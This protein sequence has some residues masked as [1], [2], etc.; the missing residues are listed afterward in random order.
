MKFF[1]VRNPCWLYME[2]LAMSLAFSVEATTLSQSAVCITGWLWLYF[3][4]QI[5]LSPSLSAESA[6]RQSVA[7]VLGVCELLTR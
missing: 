2:E 6:A 5:S 4:P 3:S 1:S 7:I